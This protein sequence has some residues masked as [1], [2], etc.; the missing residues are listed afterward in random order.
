MTINYS[1]KS[2]LLFLNSKVSLDTKKKYKIIFF[3]I[4]L[5]SFFEIIN[6][7]SVIPLIAILTNPEQINNL[8]ILKKLLEFFGLQTLNIQDYKLFI[9]LFF[10]ISIILANLIRLLLFTTSLKVAQSVSLDISA[11]VFKLSICKN[12]SEISRDKSED[13]ITVIIQKVESFSNLVFQI[14]NFISSSLIIFFYF[15]LLVFLLGFKIILFTVC[16]IGFSY[17]GIA[18]YVNSKLQKNSQKLNILS[19]ERLKFIKESLANIKDI[20]LNVDQYKYSVFF[21]NIDFKFKEAQTKITTI[22]GIPR[23]MLEVLI[24]SVILIV[25]FFI[26]ENSNSQKTHETLLALGL[27][28][29][30]AQRL[31]PLVQSVYAAW[32]TLIGNKFYLID[33]RKSLEFES[34]INNFNNNLQINNFN[35]N[36]NF[37]KNI[38]FKNIYFQYDNSKKILDNFNFTINKGT[39]VAIIGSSGKGKSTL[40]DITIGL[41][42]PTQGSIY[43]DE[44][45]IEK[46][47]INDWRSKISHVPQ[48]YFIIDD[49]IA[50]NIAFTLDKQK[51]DKNNLILSAK[52]AELHDFIMSLPNQYETQVGEE[53]SVL[54]GGQRQRLVIARALYKKKDILILDEATSALDFE[55]E[56][57]LINNINFYLPNITLI[58]ITHR[59]SK[60]KN[61]KKIINLDNPDLYK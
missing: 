46:K 33:I 1:L 15:V 42:E 34:Q 12:Y 9:F 3:F 38:V 21:K 20:L 57:R 53:G 4:I 36:L 43:I 58:L 26:S 30:S 31:F 47:N 7:G 2:N 11:E 28:G 17:F 51:I 16:V 8:T 48:E 19:K 45:K 61:I 27:I 18:L 44:Q 32:A 56:E 50:N 59:I 5:A 29:F 54:S 14:I 40:I 13:I 37:N 39:S 25:A 49:T 10:L 24:I 41:L 55:L 60:I 35:N 52:I 22:I 23:Q 6:I